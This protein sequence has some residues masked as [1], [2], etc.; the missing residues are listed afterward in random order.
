MNTQAAGAAPRVTKADIDAAIV[1]TEIVKHV[2][3]S[4][5]VLRWA[6]ITLKN[7]F[8]VH[9]RASASVSPE[10]D[11]PAIGEK[12][13]MDNAYAETWPLMGF[14]LKDRLHRQAVKEEACSR[15]TMRHPDTGA[16]CGMYLTKEG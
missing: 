14:A 12:V 3:H 5:Q 15:C 1:H 8:S 9:G 10:N 6:I 11:D 2:T 13:A 7:G 16:C 4:G